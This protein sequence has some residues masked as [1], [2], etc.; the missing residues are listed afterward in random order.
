EDSFSPGQPVLAHVFGASRKLT[1]KLKAI[2]GTPAEPS[3]PRATAWR[4]APSLPPPR[5]CDGG[6]RRRVRPMRHRASDAS[7][8]ARPR[9]VQ[10]LSCCAR[11]EYP[12]TDRDAFLLRAPQSG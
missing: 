7:V 3:C 9:E 4:S 10:S 5:P 8:V 11:T 1:P 12:A 2:A 6:W